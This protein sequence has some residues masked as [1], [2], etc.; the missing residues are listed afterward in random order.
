MIHDIHAFI[1]YL[2]FE[3]WQESRSGTIFRFTVVGA[4]DLTKIGSSVVYREIE[5][6]KRKREREK[7]RKHDAGGGIGNK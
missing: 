4:S 3:K 2:S 5:M 1:E 7:Q 6:G